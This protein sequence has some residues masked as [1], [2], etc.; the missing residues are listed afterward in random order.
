MPLDSMLVTTAVVLMFMTFGAA[1][2][3]AER[4]TAGLVAAR[5]NSQK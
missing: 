2:F 5:P 1:V 4:Q 3:W